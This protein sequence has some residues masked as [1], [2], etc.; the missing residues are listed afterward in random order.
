MLV[1]KTKT[2]EENELIKSKYNSGI[3]K[4]IRIDSL[5]KDVNTHKRTG[6]FVKWNEDLDCIWCEL[7]SDAKKKGIFKAKQEEF[8]KFNKELKDIGTIN[9]KG[10]VG[11]KKVEDEEKNKRAKHY[12]T[13]SDKEIFLR[14][15]EEDVGKGSSWDDSDED[16]F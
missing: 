8:E 1:K 7:S 16:D 13:L 4:I 14:L 10:K 3:N 6:L 2:M 15:L 9:D 5:W 12:K 11:F